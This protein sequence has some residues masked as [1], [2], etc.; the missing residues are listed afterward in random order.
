MRKKELAKAA[1]PTETDLVICQSKDDK[2]LHRMEEVLW[3]PV[4]ESGEWYAN[5]VDK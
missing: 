3:R 5:I 1:A 4:A 2:T